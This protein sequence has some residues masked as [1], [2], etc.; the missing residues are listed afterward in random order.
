[1][2]FTSHAIALTVLAGLAAG[3]IPSEALPE[4]ELDRLWSLSV[5]PTPGAPLSQPVIGEMKLP[6][7]WTIRHKSSVIVSTISIVRAYDRM[8]EG[9]ET[10]DFS[11]S[12]A[13]TRTMIDLIRDARE[14]IEA[15]ARL[16]DAG[17]GSDR[18]YWADTLAETLTDVEG[19]ARMVSIDDDRTFRD[20][21]EPG[22]I[23]AGPLLE[24]VSLYLNDRSGGALLGDLKTGEV[25]RLRAVLTQMTLRL[26]FDLAGKQLP[27]NLRES[28]AGTMKQA[29]RM[30]ALEKS[31]AGVLLA[32][33]E[34]APPAESEGETSRMFRTMTRWSP[35]GLKVLEAFLAQWHKFDRLELELRKLGEQSVLVMTVRVQ[36]GKTV[37][38]GDVLF[39]QPTMIFRGA[40][41]VVV[42][43]EAPATG[44]TTV[45]FAP[46]DGSEGAVE[47]RFE[48]LLY[49]LGRLFAFPLADGAMR[50]VRVYTDLPAEGP[51][52]VHAAVLMEAV[53]GKGDR[54]RMLVVQDVRVK[55]VV[56]KPFSIETVDVKEAQIVNYLTSTRKYSFHRQKKAAD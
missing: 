51:Q 11:I 3:C 41:R 22:G 2:K 43:P 17:D 10:I 39:M 6:S 16:A 19:I 56:R 50:E 4:G 42:L 1:M 38:V 28:I 47:M 27:G 7:R 24:L 31:L 52:M 40:T 35:R 26:G 53:R 8:K 9:V 33:V 55:K 21:E 44:E 34:K 18:Q 32:E 37:R 36:P 12:P 23:A 46:V 13:H 45:M 30:D 25:G 54:R 48:G 14:V 29:K 5:D 20:G 49:G 15:L